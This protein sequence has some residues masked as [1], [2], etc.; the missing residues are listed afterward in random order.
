MPLDAMHE[1]H[2]VQLLLARD[3]QLRG[4]AEMLLGCLAAVQVRLAMP[5][6][7]PEMWR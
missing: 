3:R 5:H 6:L 1:R 4:R 2:A 7:Q